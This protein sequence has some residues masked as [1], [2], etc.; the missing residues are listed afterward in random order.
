MQPTEPPTDQF[1]AVDRHPHH[2]YRPRNILLGG[3]VALVAFAATGVIVSASTAKPRPAPT[4]TA[5]EQITV[6]GPTPTVTKTT[7][8]K[9][10]ETK[11][12]P[13][14]QLTVASYTGTGNWNS[15]QFTV[16]GGPLTVKFSYWNNTTGYGGDNFIADL[17]SSDDDLSIA[18]D[19]ATSGGKTTTLYPSSSNPY[20]LEVTATGPWSVTITEQ[21]A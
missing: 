3:G 8:V 12:V 16:S 18:N 13:P 11:I 20:H 6:P 1:P 21:P 5:T 9:V 14:P 17:T 4:V 7:H 19:I 10:T 15:P 2:W